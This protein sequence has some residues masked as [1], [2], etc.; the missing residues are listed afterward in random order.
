VGVEM[1]ILDFNKEEEVEE[2]EVCIR[3]PNV[4]AGYLNN[5]SANKSSFTV[6]GGY[7]RTGDRGKIDADGLYVMFP[8]SWLKRDSLFI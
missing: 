6:P 5:A 4:T 1:K 7:F 2:G 3:G 8:L